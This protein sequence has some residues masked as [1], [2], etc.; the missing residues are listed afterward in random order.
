MFRTSAI[1]MLGAALSPQ[2][3]R[4]T[5]RK[6]KGEK[7]I[8]GS[9]WWLPIGSSGSNID[10]RTAGDNILTPNIIFANSLFLLFFLCV[11]KGYSTLREGIRVLCGERE[12]L[13]YFR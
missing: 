12:S 10:S 7:S 3:T 11:L 4:R 8:D 6:D 5:Q 1:L 2:R 9:F 13:G